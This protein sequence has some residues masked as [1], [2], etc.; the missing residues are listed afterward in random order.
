MSVLFVF[1]GGGRRRGVDENSGGETER[2][3]ME[4][5]TRQ[6]G[7]YQEHGDGMLVDRAGWAK[8]GVICKGTSAGLAG[9]SLKV[10]KSK[11]SRISCG[12]FFPGPTLSCVPRFSIPKLEIS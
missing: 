6:M 12:Y 3:I 2:A 4:G 8:S 5:G 7:G 11:H 10:E 9:F 1:Y